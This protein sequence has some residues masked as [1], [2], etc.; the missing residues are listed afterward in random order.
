M[1]RPISKKEKRLLK[2]LIKSD[3]DS[4]GLIDFLSHDWPDGKI[5]VSTFQQTLSL[6]VEDDQLPDVMHHLVDR[7]NFVKALEKEGYINLWSQL[8]TTDN[9]KSCGTASDDA[10]TIFVPDIAIAT[11]I[12]KYANYHISFSDSLIEWSK[13]NFRNRNDF[14]LLK[15]SVYVFIVLLAADLI[16]HAHGIRSSI[17][18]D[19]QEIVANSQELIENQLLSNQIIDSLR[20]QNKN[21][22]EITNRISS[23]TQNMKDVVGLVRQQQKSIRTIQ[24]QFDMLDEQ[25]SNDRKFLLKADSLLTRLTKRKP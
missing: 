12:L 8:P 21:L 15:A 1:R 9:T 17:S 5:E 11:D 14:S 16:Y 19:H 10:K 13:R 23:N 2:R 20:L 3:R 4:Y 18:S 6:Q 24:S 25:L 7:L 22:E